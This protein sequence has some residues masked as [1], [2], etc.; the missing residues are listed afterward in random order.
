MGNKD[1]FIHKCEIWLEDI[2][3]NEK[4]NLNVYK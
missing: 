2:I 3:F 4:V 1:E